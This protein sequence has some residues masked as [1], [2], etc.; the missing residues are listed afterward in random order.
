MQAIDDQEEVNFPVDEP[1]TEV[2]ITVRTN[3]Y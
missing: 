2:Q 3:R 1:G